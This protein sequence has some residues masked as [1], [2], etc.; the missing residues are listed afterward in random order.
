MKIR[1]L[2]ESTGFEPVRPV[3][4]RH[5][6][7]VMLSATQPTPHIRT[8]V[9]KISELPLQLSYNPRILCVLTSSLYIIKSNFKYLFLLF[10]CHILSP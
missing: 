7:S 3:K 8:L 5:V 1:I 6:S 9:R 4:V 2:A 10:S